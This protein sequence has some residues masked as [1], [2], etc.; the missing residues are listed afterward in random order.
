MLARELGLTPSVAADLANSLRRKYAKQG[1][2]FVFETVCSDPVGDQLAFLPE[3]AKEGYVIV[4]CSIGI[5][6][7]DPCEQHVDVLKR[8]IP[9]M[10]PIADG[11]TES[12]GRVRRDVL[13]YVA[14]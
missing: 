6:N 4:L 2:S 9:R 10:A 12:D 13:A 3:A 14:G 5:S 11:M 1:E 8:S 7:S